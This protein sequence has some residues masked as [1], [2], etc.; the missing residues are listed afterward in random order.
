MQRSLH[1]QLFLDDRHEH[2]DGFGNL[3]AGLRRV[4]R[5]AVEALDTQTQSFL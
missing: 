3:A 1:V 4:L 2:V 5:C